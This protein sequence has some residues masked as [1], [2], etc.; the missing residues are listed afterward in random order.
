MIGLLL[1]LLLVVMAT[2]NQSHSRSRRGNSDVI[3]D[4]GKRAALIIDCSQTRC[5]QTTNEQFAA[6]NVYTHY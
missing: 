4:D 6:A 5:Q 3:N 1:M 2:G